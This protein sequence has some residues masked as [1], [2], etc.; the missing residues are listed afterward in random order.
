MRAETEENYEKQE[1]QYQGRVSN[2]VPAPCSKQ[3]KY[4]KN[5]FICKNNCAN[6]HI[7][8]V[9]IQRQDKVSHFG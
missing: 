1:S 8:I 2:T 4:L 5:Q 7:T 3:C 9:T 6:K